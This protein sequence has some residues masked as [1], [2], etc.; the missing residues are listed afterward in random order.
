MFRNDIFWLLPA[1]LISV[2]QV[3]WIWAK[4]PDFRESETLMPGE[5]GESEVFRFNYLTY[6]TYFILII[7]LAYL[8]FLIFGTMILLKHTI[9]EDRL[10]EKAFGNKFT[11]YR[12]KTKMFLPFLF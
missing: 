11:A 2:L 9:K 10:L 7:Q 1:I 12:K 6:V 4:L 3:K 5:Y 8:L